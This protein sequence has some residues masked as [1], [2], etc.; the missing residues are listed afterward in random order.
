MIS[1]IRLGRFGACRLWFTNKTRTVSLRINPVSGIENLLRMHNTVHIH[2]ERPAGVIG[3]CPLTQP[4]RRR[5]QENRVLVF[6][7]ELMCR[8]RNMDKHFLR[9]PK[10][11]KEGFHVCF[12]SLR[13]EIASD[14]EGGN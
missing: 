10:I 5:P 12:G 3:K 6:P 9:R 4:L 14:E 2:K 13:I 7:N 11:C 8:A 1:L